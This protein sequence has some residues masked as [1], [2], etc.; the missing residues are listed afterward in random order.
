MSTNNYYDFCII[1]SGAAGL[2]AAYKLSNKS[3][4]CILCEI[5]NSQHED[6]SFY[7]LKFK[8]EGNNHYNGSSKGRSFG[9]GGT[10]FLWGAS[11]IPYTKMDFQFEDSYGK[12]FQKIKKNIVEFNHDRLL[13]TLIGKKVDDKI[14][15]NWTSNYYNKFG[16]YET[17]NV[18]IPFNRKDFSKIF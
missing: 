6:D 8:L 2:Y 13:K 15:K 10:T 11:L 16:Y 5:G 7:D 18:Y 12:Y 14:L 9:I 3:K 4:K 1:G 17:N